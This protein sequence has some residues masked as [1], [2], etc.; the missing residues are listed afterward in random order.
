M[1]VLPK[2]DAVRPTSQTGAPGRPRARAPRARSVPAGSL[3]VFG[4][5]M[6]GTGTLE[7]VRAAKRLA[8]SHSGLYME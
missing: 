6:R 1:P 2:S 5:T 8:E 7:Q 3:T 4:L